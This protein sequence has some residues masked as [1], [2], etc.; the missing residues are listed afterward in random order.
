M[1]LYHDQGLSLRESVLG[2]SDDFCEDSRLVNSQLAE[3]LA[4]QSDPGQ[5]ETI[6][7]LG[8][9]QVVLHACCVDT[10]D[11]QGA[12]FPLLGAAVAK[13]IRPGADHRFSDCAPQPAPSTPEPFRFAENAIL[14]F[15]TG[16][17]V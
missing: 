6:N 1:F 15:A 5:I 17:S 16:F 8:V 11:P 13:C 2:S 9:T 7:E 4:V 12:E 10:S 14:L 3:R